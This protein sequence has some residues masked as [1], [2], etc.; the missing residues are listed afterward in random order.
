[1]TDAERDAFIE[2]AMWARAE[3]S[4]NLTEEEV[5]ELRTRGLMPSADTFR[6][7]ARERA[8]DAY[9]PQGRDD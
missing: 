7:Q 6:E 1:M 9:E 8:S 2:G 3:L 5:A 4:A